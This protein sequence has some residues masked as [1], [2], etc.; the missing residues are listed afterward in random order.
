MTLLVGSSQE[1]PDRERA[2]LD[3]FLEQRV[4]GVLLSP[5]D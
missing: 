1:D 3:L 4:S 2:Y 5:V